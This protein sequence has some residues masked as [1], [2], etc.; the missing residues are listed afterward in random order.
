MKMENCTA[1]KPGCE[2]VGTDGNV[3]ALAGRVGKCL[4]RAGLPEQATEMYARLQECHSYDEAL[5]LFTEY[6]D[7]Y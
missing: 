6:V 4:K 7:A 5:A 1:A 2:L 3:F